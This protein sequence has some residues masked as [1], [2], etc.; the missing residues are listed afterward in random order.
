MK[1]AA[2]SSSEAPRKKLCLNKKL[3]PSKRFGSV[4]EEESL[5][6]AK[7]VVPLN[8]K[9]TNEWALRNLRTWMETRN[10]NCAEKVPNDLLSCDDA[11]VVCK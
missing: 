7:G 4:S 3:S 10:N 5:L 8:T 1:R 11:E 6:A 9:V 2:N